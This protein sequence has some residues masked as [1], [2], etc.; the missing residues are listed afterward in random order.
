[1]QGY[2]R[3]DHR[4]FEMSETGRLTDFYHFNSLVGFDLPVLFI[5][6]F[7]QSRFLK[8]GLQAKGMDSFSKEENRY[9]F[10]RAYWRV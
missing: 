9:A 1:M 3:S 7:F 4:P 10:I 2:G 5:S 8:H 6:H